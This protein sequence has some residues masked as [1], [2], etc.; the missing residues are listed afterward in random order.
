MKLNEKG[1]CPECLKKPLTYKRDR[2]YFCNRCD[3][4]FDMATKE[5]I[6]NF[7]WRGPYTQVPHS[8]LCV[9]GKC[10]VA[11]EETPL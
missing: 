6:P 3:R 5:F 11:A 4:L 1:Q 8:K 10:P 7:H 9:C 2:V